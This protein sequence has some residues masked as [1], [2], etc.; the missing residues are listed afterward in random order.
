MSDRFAMTDRQQEIYDFVI[1][2]RLRKGYSPT[3]AEIAEEFDF[4]SANAA[5][6]HVSCIVDKGHLLRDYGISRSL[7]PVVS[8]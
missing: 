2:F 4:K 8:V 6:E 3:I 5:Q 7:R 1:A